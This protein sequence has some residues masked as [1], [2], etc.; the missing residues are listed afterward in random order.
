VSSFCFFFRAS[1]R[2]AHGIVHAD[3]VLHAL[4]ID[5]DELLACEDGWGEGVRR[6][7]Q[8]RALCVAREGEDLRG[9][10]C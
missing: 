4:G 1:A 5:E 7:K 3:V 10:L 6:N 2:D 9:D 8:G